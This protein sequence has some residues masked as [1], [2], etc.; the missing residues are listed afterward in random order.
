MEWYEELD[1]DENPFETDSLDSDF[2]IIG[3]DKECDEVIYKISSGNLL[4]I[5]GPEGSGKTALL[6]HAI[7]NFKGKG[8]VIYVDANKLS[9][10]LDINELIRKKP[11]G[12]ILLMDNIDYISQKNNEK[13]K[14]Y[15]DEDKIR[16]VVFTTKDYSK[17][18][19]SEA[20][21]NRIGNSIIKLTNPE[22]E[23]AIEIIYDRLQNNSEILPEN[24]LKKLF[25]N[26]KN[27]KLFFQECDTLCEYLV[28]NDKDK[29]TLKDLDNIKKKTKVDESNIDNEL[30]SV[31]ENK[32][33]KIRDVWR[34]ENCD[35]YC[36]G[37]GSLV[38]DEDDVCPGCGAMFDE[39]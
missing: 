8:K 14:Y 1:M 28:D 11:K 37:C 33:I 25:S 35:Q 6:K 20:I 23:Q 34:C 15:Y 27:L 16:A 30:C 7:D 4:V 9:K 36:L 3:K 39:V 29:A 10:R 19:F 22:V 5:E 18:N 26:S 21:K 31:C 24:V 13:L 38:D 32:L 12:M 2:E 17:V